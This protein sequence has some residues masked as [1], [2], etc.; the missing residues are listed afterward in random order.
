VLLELSYT[1]TYNDPVTGSVSDTE[2]ASPYR[3]LCTPCDPNVLPD[4]RGC[5]LVLCEV[6]T[7]SE[8]LLLNAVAV[9]R[10]ICS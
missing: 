8:C 9:G 4:M 5:Y 2:L 3:H 1:T 10:A 6:W 7:T